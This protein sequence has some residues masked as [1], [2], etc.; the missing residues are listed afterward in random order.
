MLGRIELEEVAPRGEHV[1]GQILDPRRSAELRG[2]RAVIL[3]HGPH[4][5]ELG[6]HPEAA[7][8][9]GP[10]VK[11]HRRLLLQRLEHLPRLVVGE[12]VVVEQIDGQT[13][14]RGDAHARSASYQ[15]PQFA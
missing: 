4:V 14:S 2:E 6:D 11:V 10:G 3:Q 5:V 1:L 7:I 8:A 12:Q 9:V 15:R 13:G